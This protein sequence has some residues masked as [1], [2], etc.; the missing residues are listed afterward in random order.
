MRETKNLF[1]LRYAFYSL[2]LLF[3]TLPGLSEIYENS[4]TLGF[5]LNAVGFE[6]G[7]GAPN[8]DNSI[9]LLG[10]GPS[11]GLSYKTDKN[12][13]IQLTIKTGELFPSS[14]SGD[15]LFAFSE[16]PLYLS[17]FFEA[18]KNSSF[19]LSVGGNHWSVGYDMYYTSSAIGFK[20]NFGNFD[21]L[22]ILYIGCELQWIRISEST[23]SNNIVS[24]NLILGPLN[25]KKNFR[26]ANN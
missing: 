9:H 17:L 20:Q 16:F 22:P 26:A 2:L 3:I 24:F 12:L 14:F 13:G 23:M 6:A 21:N 19:Y 18:N 25:I 5:E 7:V 15:Y 11:F 1:D 10:E 8:S 4:Q